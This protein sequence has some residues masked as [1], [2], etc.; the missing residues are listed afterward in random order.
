[1]ELIDDVL[2]VI[3]WHSVASASCARA[4][5]CKCSQWLHIYNFF[6]TE[7]LVHSKQVE[8]HW[9]WFLALYR[10][11][12]NLCLLHVAK[13]ALTYE[14]IVLRSYHVFHFF[15]LDWWFFKFHFEESW[16]T[17][18]VKLSFFLFLVCFGYF[19]LTRCDEINIVYFW[20]ALFI[21]YLASYILSLFH[22]VRNF[23]YCIWSQLGKYTIIF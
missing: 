3:L 14:P 2:K 17:V 8:L 9:L 7:D 18:R 22:V 16:H 6:H 5:N 13:D 19:E 12:G 1:M 21:N 23:G 11:V 15:A 10:S 4:Y 20:L